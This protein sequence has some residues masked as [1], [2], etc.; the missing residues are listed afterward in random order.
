MFID[1]RIGDYRTCDNM[2]ITSKEIVNPT[3]YFEAPPGADVPAEMERFIEWFN[4]SREDPNVTGV[5]RAAIA[6]LWFETIHPYDDGNGRVG[7]AVADKVLSQDIGFPTVAC[8]STAIL[9]D[10]NS[11]YD[12]INKA[13]KSLDVTDWVE[14]FT[15]TTVRAYDIALDKIDLVLDKTR[16]WKAHEKSDLNPRQEKALNKMFSFTPE[17]SGMTA[18]KY[19]SIAGCSK[20][21]ATRD[22]TELA[23]AGCVYPEGKGRSVKYKLSIPLKQPVGEVSFEGLDLDDAMI[24]YDE[25]EQKH[26]ASERER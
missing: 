9:E 18:K 2:R 25:A 26:N 10:K 5:E 8:L 15:R 13:S 19:M 3:I 21:T 16:F 20:A 24:S 6:H 14:W 22:L 12:E 1:L 11:Y 7:R 17:S 23:V 4:A